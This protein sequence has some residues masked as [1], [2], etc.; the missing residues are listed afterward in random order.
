MNEA[1]CRRIVKER[2]NLI[3]ELCPH[4]GVQMHHRKNRSQGGRWEPSN[5]LHLCVP[6]HT[7]FTE[8]PLVSWQQG[9]TVRRAESPSDKPVLVRGRWVLLTDDGGYADV[10]VKAS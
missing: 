7:W 9:W 8:H 4:S 6:C 5:I 2:S 10:E 3:C 1:K